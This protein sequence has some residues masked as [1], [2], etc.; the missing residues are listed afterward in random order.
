MGFWGLFKKREAVKQAKE[1]DEIDVK[2]LESSIRRNRNEIYR[3][4]LEALKEKQERIL[5]EEQIAEAE[6][7]LSEFTDDLDAED[8]E[9][10]APNFMNPDALIGTLLTQ[11]LMKSMNKAPLAPPSPSPPAAPSP[12][13]DVKVSYTDDQIKDIKAK[14]P[15][16][17]LKE[18]KKM[19]NDELV[20]VI[21]EKYPTLDDDTIKRAA[22]ILRA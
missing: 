19:D 5:L 9:Q 22:V 12:P 2:R 14:I 13:P 1:P 11:F 4:R 3:R 6:E 16:A 17:Y 15:K 18:F 20:G 7:Q 8:E 10:A 21:M